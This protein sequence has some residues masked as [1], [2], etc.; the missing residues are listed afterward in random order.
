MFQRR[1]AFIRFF[2]KAVECFFAVAVFLDDTTGKTGHSGITATFGNDLRAPVGTAGHIC[3]K[4]F[5]GQILT[6]GHFAGVQFDLRVRRSKEETGSIQ[7]L[8]VEIR[9]NGVDQFLHFTVCC[10]I[11]HVLN[12][13]QHV[14][15]GTSGFAVFL[16]HIK[17]AVVNGKCNA[18]KSRP[19]ISGSDPIVRI[20][21]VVV[22]AVHRKTV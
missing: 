8:G 1:S 13:K 17:A 22:I 10:S 21:G 15:L 4:I 16:T 14:E 2:H 19:D 3:V 9:E 18:R 5:C 11:C 20:L 12:G 6:E 7:C